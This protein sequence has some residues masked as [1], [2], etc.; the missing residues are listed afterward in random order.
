MTFTTNERPGRPLTF[1]PNETEGPNLTEVSHRSLAA[2]SDYRD[3]KLV[4]DL[5]IIR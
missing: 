4:R 5:A 2:A 1:T 3:G